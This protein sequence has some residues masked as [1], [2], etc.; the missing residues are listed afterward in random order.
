MLD[1]KRFRVLDLT[2]LQGQFAGKILADLGLEVIK[3]EPPG[4]DAVRRLAPFR[5][6]VPD[7]EASLPFLY[8]NSNKKSITLNLER[9]EGRE[10]LKTLARQSDILLESFPPGEMERW[11]AGYQALAQENPG[12]VM[13]SITGFGQ[14]GPY[15]SYRSSDLVDLAMGG[16]LYVFGEPAKPPCKPPETQA[17]YTASAYAALGSL[18]ALYHRQVSGRG[19]H[20][21]ISIQEAL[22]VIDQII[23]SAANE[24]LV[25]RRDGAQHKQVSPANV[26]P[27]RDGHVYL[28][29]S[30]AGNHWKQFLNLW[31]DHPAAFDEPE[32]E[33]PGHRRQN[34]AA[35]NDA[36]RQFTR[37][38][39]RADLVE[40]MQSH[41]I[42]C[43]PVNTPQEFLQDEQIQARGFLQSVQHPRWGCYRHP[44]APYLVDGQ[45]MPIGPAPSIGQHNAEVYGK[46]L[47][48]ELH[49][50]ALLRAANVI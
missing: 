19:Q 34:T 14:E 38:F 49:D 45:R 26:F 37:R 10:L 7:P 40:Q 33:S 27:C 3:V 18:F 11:G 22:A 36:V 16:L 32:W 48:L 25:L 50:L 41:G 30:A 23:S 47:N 2:D 42:P 1:L 21:D 8:L 15:A 29:V 24:K 44:G 31:P 39:S 17:F 46:L 5:D 43:L 28:F 4:G 13:A 20:L 9:E 12:L 35:I 6:R